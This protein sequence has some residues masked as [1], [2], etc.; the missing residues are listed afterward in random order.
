MSKSSRVKS[1]LLA[2]LLST[3][4]AFASTHAGVTQNLPMAQG[5]CAFNSSPTGTIPRPP[6]G[7]GSLAY[8][9]PTGTIPRPPIG[10]G[11]LAYSSPTGT[12]P[13]PPIGSGSL[14]YSSPT[15][16]IP[17]PPIGSGSL[18]S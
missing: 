8:S 6:I 11:S 7:S 14:A 17:R 1:Y 16:T 9:S 13:R 5:V 15:G 4:G 2:F 12:I 3:T 10:S 18:A